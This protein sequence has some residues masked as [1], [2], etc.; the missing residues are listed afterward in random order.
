MVK[1]AVAKKFGRKKTIESKVKPR[2]PDSETREFV[3]I[4][5]AYFRIFNSTVKEYAPEIVKIIKEEKR[6][7][8]ADFRADSFG[9][10]SRKITAVFQKIFEK[11]EKR[12]SSYSLEKFVSKIANMTKTNT[13]KEWKRVVKK[14]LGVDIMEDYYS[15]EFY[16]NMLK[17]WIDDNVTAIKTLPK[18]SLENMKQIILEGYENGQ[19]VGAIQKKIQN[20]YNVSK[21]KAILLAR[22]QISTL[23]SLITQAQ[24]RDAGVTKYKWSDSGDQRVRECH[25]ALSG[26]IFS[27][28]NPPQMW[29]RT[30]KGIVYSERRCH[31]GED[32]ECRCVAIPVFEI[33]KL[34]LPIKADNSDNTINK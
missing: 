34:D 16:G 19:A 5:R 29:Y 1:G 26:K 10:F 30:K 25:R 8:S 33:D 21:S 27:W 12:L 9:D 31:P 24:Q 13:A 18:D 3:R 28:D 17:Q 4:A 14:T 2:Q 11:L 20:E 15:S 23:N 22:D 6:E 7:D 32:Y